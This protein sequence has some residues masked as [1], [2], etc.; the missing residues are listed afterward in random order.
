MGSGP[1]VL[2]LYFS[3]MPFLSRKEISNQ[4]N[5]KI[6][7]AMLVPLKEILRIIKLNQL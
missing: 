2:M 3:R 1:N 5:K 4:Y 7:S 6:P